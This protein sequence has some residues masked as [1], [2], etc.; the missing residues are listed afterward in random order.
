MEGINSCTFSGNV[1]RKPELQY[2]KTSNT[3]VLNFSIA[4]NERSKGPNGK[5]IE[6]PNYIDFSL[7]G[8][9]AE[10]LAKRIDVG[11]FVCINSKARR[12]TWTKDGEKKTRITFVVE[13]INVIQGETKR[14]K[15]EGGK[16]QQGYEQ[17]AFDDFDE[18]SDE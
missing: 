16:P 13:D 5:M 7:F 14:S 6:E 12:G 4:C 3:P 2:T 17:Y 9:R 10:S 1:T 11:T 15:A 8:S 18:D